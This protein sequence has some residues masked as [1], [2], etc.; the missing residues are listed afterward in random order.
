MTVVTYVYLSVRFR[1]VTRD[2]D[3][4]LVHRITNII[5]FGYSNM[6]IYSFTGHGC[7]R[8]ERMGSEILSVPRRDNNFN[9]T[10]DHI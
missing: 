8:V 7:R 4:Q 5:Y 3:R 10:G 1:C 2:F 6:L 9:G